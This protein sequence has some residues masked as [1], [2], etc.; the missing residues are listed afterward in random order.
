MAYIAHHEEVAWARMLGSSRKSAQQSRDQF[1]GYLNRNDKIQV[2]QQTRSLRPC[3][4]GL[5][6][7]CK[8]RP[9]RSIRRPGQAAR[10]R[11][12][13]GLTRTRTVPVTVAQGTAVPRHRECCRAGARP[14]A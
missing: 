4:P 8:A 1:A 6:P 14:A 11:C 10:R 2:D 5:L 13:P 7:S 9:V 12:Q 3:R